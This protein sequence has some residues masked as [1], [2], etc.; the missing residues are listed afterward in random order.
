MARKQGVM[1]AATGYLRGRV[2]NTSS[3][4]CG[5]AVAGRAT[6]GA[7]A[8]RAGYPDTSSQ[9]GSRAPNGKH[10]ELHPPPGRGASGG[11]QRLQGGLEGGCTP[12]LGGDVQEFG[13]GFSLLR[14][15]EPGTG[16]ALERLGFSLFTSHSRAPFPE[17]HPQDLLPRPVMIINETQSLKQEHS[18][19]HAVALRDQEKKNHS[20]V[21]K[22]TREA[23]FSP[24]VFGGL[25]VLAASR[26]SGS[27]EE[28]ICRKRREI[29]KI[30][31]K[32][33]W[34]PNLRAK[35]M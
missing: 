5:V 14:V 30:F 9:D 7:C 1:K 24:W 19:Q 8:R 3:W 10:D 13:P 2:A 34:S 32:R 18:P 20:K 25:V 4:A 17:T 23:S 27:R 33:G 22:M 26:V 11:T 35:K 15:R 6:H 31:Y 28:S 21:I 29:Q 12:N 16:S